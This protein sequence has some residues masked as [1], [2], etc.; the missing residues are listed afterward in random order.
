[1]GKEDQRKK[2]NLLLFFFFFPLFSGGR[3]VVFWVGV[4]FQFG[5]FCLFLFSASL[6][7]SFEEKLFKLEGGGRK[8]R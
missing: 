8:T 7:Q 1:M 5:F 2:T 4:F 6:Q 3:G